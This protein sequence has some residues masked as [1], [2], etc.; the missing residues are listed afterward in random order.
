MER[1]RWEPRAYG[2]IT[3]EYRPTNQD[4]RAHLTGDRAIWAAGRSPYEAVGDLVVHHPERFAAQ[5]AV[6]ELKDACRLLFTKWDEGKP[7]LNQVLER[8]RILIETDDAQPP[9]EG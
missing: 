6:A 2:P 4:F 5:A 8:I 1:P 7:S 9:S 3:V